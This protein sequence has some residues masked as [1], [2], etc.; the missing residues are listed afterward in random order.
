MQLSQVDFSRKVSHGDPTACGDLVA[1]LKTIYAESE[2]MVRDAPALATTKRNGLPNNIQSRRLPT[3]IRSGMVP[4]RPSSGLDQDLPNPASSVGGRRTYIDEGKEDSTPAARSEQTGG[5][6]SAKVPSRSNKVRY[7]RRCRVHGNKGKSETISGKV[8]LAGSQQGITGNDQRDDGECLLTGSSQVKHCSMGKKKDDIRRHKNG[9][10]V[11][12]SEVGS[13]SYGKTARA[14]RESLAAHALSPRA[15]ESVGGI[16]ARQAN[17]N[18]CGKDEAVIF[19]GNVDV[20]TSAGQGE[21]RSNR[22]RI[23][24]WMDHLGLKVLCSSSSMFLKIISKNV[25][26]FGGAQVTEFTNQRPEKNTIA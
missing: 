1:F 21:M 22:R 17:Q 4:T 25:V 14:V 19:C 13:E 15:S 9:Q 2:T 24:R 16:V 12:A 11:M 26:G 20:A 10:K 7:E 18:R 6:P 5:A 3:T 23:L 8:S